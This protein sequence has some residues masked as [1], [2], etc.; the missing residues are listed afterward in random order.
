MLA[1]THLVIGIFGIILFWPLVNAPIPFAVVVLIASLFPDI[2]NAFSRV[3]KN[4]PAKLVQVVT[5]HRGFIH[6]LTFCVLISVILS[7]FVP[8]LAFGFFLGY[9]LHLG[10]PI[11]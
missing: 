4:I 6:S 10:G 9:S 3:G 5:E 2:D 8:I 7:V 11:C 1:R